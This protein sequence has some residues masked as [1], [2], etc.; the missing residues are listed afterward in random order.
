MEKS[1]IIT[2]T[3]YYRES[4]ILENENRDLRKEINDIKESY[5]RQR[6]EIKNYSIEE[7]YEKAFIKFHDLLK[8]DAYCAVSLLIF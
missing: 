1:R 6:A 3:Q 5:I 8:K 7:L 4:K 2:M